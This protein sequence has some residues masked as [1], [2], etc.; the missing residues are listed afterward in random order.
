MARFF[1]ESFW[2]IFLGQEGGCIR[3]VA[4]A[5]KVVKI[6]ERRMGREWYLSQGL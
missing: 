4:G 3:W 2:I 1:K 6:N 5:E